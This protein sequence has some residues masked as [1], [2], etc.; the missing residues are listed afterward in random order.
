MEDD[1][2]LEFEAFSGSV[3]SKAGY[4]FGVSD[5][6]EEELYWLLSP[7]GKLVASFLVERPTGSEGGDAI[8]EFCQA[9]LKDVLGWKLRH[10]PTLIDEFSTHDQNADRD[11]TCKML[12]LLALNLGPGPVV[13]KGGALV[14]WEKQEQTS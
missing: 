9:I 11:F 6:G 3:T 5:R 12:N 10:Q 7:S 4:S 14:K 1:D 13:T 2:R 8:I